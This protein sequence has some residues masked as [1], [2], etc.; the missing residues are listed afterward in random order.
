[1]RVMMLV[2]S[3]MSVF[4][5][6]MYSQDV[7]EFEST[8]AKDVS[9]LIAP[10]LK[11]YCVLENLDCTSLTQKLFGESLKEEKFTSP[12]RLSSKKH[13]TGNW[14]YFMA[15]TP[16]IYEIVKIEKDRYA[17]LYNKKDPTTILTDKKSEWRIA[18][19]DN[20]LKVMMDK[21]FVTVWKYDNSNLSMW[22]MICTDME[23][24]NNKIT[25][26]ITYVEAERGADQEFTATANYDGTF[27]SIIV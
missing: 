14:T 19:I 27:A 24:N 18:L 4:I 26:K 22:N 10:Y 25:V 23:F 11:S 2:A 3:F 9:D 1:M 8:Q 16:L 12:R 7:K 6:T 17:V 15:K 5:A 13:I 21:P 20:R